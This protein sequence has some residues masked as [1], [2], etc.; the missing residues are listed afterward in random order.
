MSKNNDMI[1]ISWI[2]GMTRA[3]NTTA[4]RTA[5]Y[6]AKLMEKQGLTNREAALVQYTRTLVYTYAIGSLVNAYK[7][8][9]DAEQLEFLQEENQELYN[10]A[11]T[12]ESRLE[13]INRMNKRTHHGNTALDA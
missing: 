9:K 2:M 7:R 12:A 4:K 10:R 5:K 11:V 3:V 8:Y 13:F 1:H 6:R